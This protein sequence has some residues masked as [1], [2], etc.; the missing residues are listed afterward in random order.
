MVPVPELHHGYLVEVDA[1]ADSEPYLRDTPARKAI[2]AGAHTLNDISNATL[3]G[4]KQAKNKPM[5]KVTMAEVQPAL[6]ENLQK[7]EKLYIP[8]KTKKTEI[9]QGSPGEIAKKL[10][11]KFGEKIFDIIETQSAK[12]VVGLPDSLP[13]W[14]RPLPFSYQSTGVETRFTNGLDPEPRSRATF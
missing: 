5:R 13:A 9:I 3:I 11:E 14:A 8:Q 6:S 7:I 1:I 10:V 12:Y 4:I 2:G